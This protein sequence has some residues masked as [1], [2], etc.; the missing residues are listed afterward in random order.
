[1]E[2]TMSRSAWTSSHAAALATVAQQQPPQQPPP[3]LLR[4]AA[5][6]AAAAAALQPG[7]AAAQQDGICRTW[8]RGAGT[9]RA[10]H[11]AL[12]H[13]LV[14]LGGALIWQ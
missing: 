1:M 11:G 9:G 13:E 6:A 5:A 10:S 14:P 2:N 3:A 12:V 4:A 7:S 8:C